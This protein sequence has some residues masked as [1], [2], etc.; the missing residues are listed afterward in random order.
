MARRERAFKTGQHCDSKI[1]IATF[2]RFGKMPFENERPGRMG[3]EGAAIRPCGKSEGRDGMDV[4]D[5]FFESG[6]V[7]Q[8]PGE[9]DAGSG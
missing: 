4:Q 2:F 1:A 3:L 5:I 6:I 7:E 8:P 9:S